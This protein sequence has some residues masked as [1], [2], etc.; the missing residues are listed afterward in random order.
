MVN[1]ILILVILTLCIVCV[2]KHIKFKRYQKKAM[3]L[4]KDGSAFQSQMIEQERTIKLELAETITMNKAL[5]AHV[6][7]QEQNLRTLQ[8]LFEQKK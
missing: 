1:I 6:I 4:I 8:K 7:E 2:Y 5:K 3:K